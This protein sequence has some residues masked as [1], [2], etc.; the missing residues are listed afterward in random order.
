MS[1]LLQ[2]RVPAGS[3]SK[4]SKRC[5]ARQVFTVNPR[6]EEIRRGAQSE[7][8]TRLK[9]DKEKKA[10]RGGM[11]ESNAIK[12]CTVSHPS[13]ARSRVHADVEVTGKH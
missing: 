12:K 1:L 6:G 11:G 9:R 2:E 5:R 8:F 10:W 7:Q 4:S 3:L 13:C